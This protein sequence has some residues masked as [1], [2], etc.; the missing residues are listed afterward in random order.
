MCFQSV[1]MSPLMK[2]EQLHIFNKVTVFIDAEYMCIS[3]NFEGTT[4]S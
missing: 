1:S 3:S 4:S 2:H